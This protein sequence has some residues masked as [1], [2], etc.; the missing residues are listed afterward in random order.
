[1][2]TQKRTHSLQKLLLFRLS[3]TQRFAVGTLKV[4]EISP[5][6]PLRVLPHSHPA[7]KGTM[8]FRESTIPVVDIAFALGYGRSANNDHKN[9]SIIITDIQRQEVGFLVHQVERIVDVDWK[10]VSAPPKGVGPAAFITGTIEID[11]SI[12]Q[13]M[14]VELVLARVLPDPAAKKITTLTDRETEALR[15]LNILLVDDSQVARRQLADVLDRHNIPFE[16]ATDGHQAQNI[17]FA[18]QEE[19]RPVDL[20]V[21]DIEMPGMD[22]Y[23]LT[24][25]IRNDRSLKQPFIIL[26]TSLNSEMS[27]SYARQ[28]GADEA[29]T[30]FDAHELLDTMLTGAGHIR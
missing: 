9:S 24:F 3:A 20:L 30:K 16:M 29:L 19:G 11:N 12:V 6:V 27:V 13:L 7:V 28:V 2:S 5:M 23:E 17:V 25:N 10:N 1:M 15:A 26:H 21:S 14:D 18:A 22:G 4:R 8:T